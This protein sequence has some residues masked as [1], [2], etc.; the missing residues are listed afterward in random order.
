MLTVLLTYVLTTTAYSLLGWLAFRRIAQHLEGNPDGIK[1]VTT[2][3]L[4]PL[5]GR[6][7]E[8]NTDT[9]RDEGK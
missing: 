1:A 6:G 2:H 8:I 9:D 7:K 4:L 3:V 5:L